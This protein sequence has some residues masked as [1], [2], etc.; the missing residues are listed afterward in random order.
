MK[1]SGPSLGEQVVHVIRAG[2]NA[3]Y[4]GVQSSCPAATPNLASKS[5]T[6]RRTRIGDGDAR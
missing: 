6:H 3:A 5:G 1:F 4:F 2:R